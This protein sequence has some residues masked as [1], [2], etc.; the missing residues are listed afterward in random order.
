MV[1][2]AVHHFQHSRLLSPP[3]TRIS[4]PVAAPGATLDTAARARSAGP[5]PASGTRF[6]LG[7]NNG[8]YG[9]NSVLGAGSRF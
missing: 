1:L 8:Y 7:L 4:G 9:H 2:V 6:L 5:G 3:P